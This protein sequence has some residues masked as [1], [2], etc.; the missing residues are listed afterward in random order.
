MNF[1]TLSITFTFRANG[2]LLST[3]LIAQIILIL[4]RIQRMGPKG[5]HPTPLPLLQTCRFLY[6]LT[7]NKIL[8][9]TGSHIITWQTDLLL[10]LL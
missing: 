3:H 8:A 7:D 10:L 1:I 9:T 2:I 5:F 6:D 4:R